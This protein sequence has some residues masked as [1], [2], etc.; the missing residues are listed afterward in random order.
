MTT[1]EPECKLCNDTKVCES[2]YIFPQL[3]SIY[4][5]PGCV[6]TVEQYDE[7]EAKHD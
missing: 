6:S 3:K 7:M 4:P 5:C 1:P 2:W